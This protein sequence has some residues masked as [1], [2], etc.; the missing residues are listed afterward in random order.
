M[1]DKLLMSDPHILL[2]DKI[3]IGCRSHDVVERLLVSL[4]AF[5]TDTWKPL[6]ACGIAL[7]SCLALIMPNT[8]M[9]QTSFS[10]ETPW[11][12]STKEINTEISCRAVMIQVKAN[13]PNNLMAV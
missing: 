8:V 1:L 13:E 4:D 7:V 11:P 9:M 12:N 6:T 3:F 10:G 2:A 5:L